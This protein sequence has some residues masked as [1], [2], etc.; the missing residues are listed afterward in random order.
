MNYNSML[1]RNQNMYF[2]SL[3]DVFV[4]L[5]QKYGE[6][7]GIE[8]P[9]NV[10]YEKTEI[11]RGTKFRASVYRMASGRYEVVDYKIKEA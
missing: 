1:K 9:Q 8:Q 3:G 2:N 6:A 7:I 4:Y 11:I 5:E 10:A